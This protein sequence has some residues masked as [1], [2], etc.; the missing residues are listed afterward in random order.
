MAQGQ[1][2]AEA[3][4]GALR[5]ALAI[6]EERSVAVIGVRD[7]PRM[8]FGK[9]RI[10]GQMDCIDES[11]NTDHFLKFM[12]AKGWLSHHRV[13]RKTSRG[14]F[15]DGR[16]PHWTA[17]LRDEQGVLWAVDSWFDPGGGPPD[18]MKLSEWKRRG[19]GGER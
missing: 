13:A 14:F 3:E 2:S 8:E 7:K 16:Y 18:V 12:E 10:V 17:V 6:F 15:L 11:T 4:R 1:K 19:V 5:D 9:A